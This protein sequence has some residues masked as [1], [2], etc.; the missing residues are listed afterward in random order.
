VGSSRDAIAVSK[1]LDRLRPEPRRPDELDP[2]PAGQRPRTLVA[3]DRP[4]EA[5]LPARAGDAD[6]L[7]AQPGGAHLEPMHHRAQRRG[8]PPA[9]R[10]LQGVDPRPR[11]GEH[12]LQPLDRA[13]QLRAF[14]QLARHLAPARCDLAFA[15]G[16]LA[17]AGGDLALEV[18]LD[19][20]D[21]AGELAPCLPLAAQDASLEELGERHRH[22]LGSGRSDEQVGGQFGERRNR[23][24]RR[25]G[26]RGNVARQVVVLAHRTGR[27]RDRP[28]RAGNR[29]RV[30]QECQQR[31]VPLGR[32][33]VVRE[34]AGVGPPGEAL[35]ECAQRG[36]DD[37][38][39]GG[40][41]HRQRVRPGLRYLRREQERRGRLGG[42]Q[43]RNRLVVVGAGGADRNP[44]SGR[45]RSPGRADH[46]EG[47]RQAPSRGVLCAADR[48]GEA[49][50]RREVAEER[51]PRRRRN[52]REVG[53]GVR[54]DIEPERGEVAGDSRRDVACGGNP[55]RGAGKRRAER[56]APGL[57]VGRPRRRPPGEAGVAAGGVGFAAV[58]AFRRHQHPLRADH[59]VVVQRPVVRNAERPRQ[60][61]RG[62]RVAVQVVEV[63]ADDRQRAEQRAQRRGFDGQ[64]EVELEVAVLAPQ[65]DVPWSRGHEAQ[66]LAA[67][68]EKPSE[69]VDV[70]AHAAAP[71]VRHHQNG[72]ARRD[73]E[74]VERFALRGLREFG[75][76][77][78]RWRESA[79]EVSPEPVI[80][81]VRRAG[82]PARARV[83]VVNRARAPAAGGR[84]PASANR[85]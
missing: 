78:Q 52:E 1:R 69:L 29:G 57:D 13:L 2:Q 56:G 43:R 34:Q 64:R 30:A 75:G 27:Q 44:G 35:G 36:R 23:R 55:P 12:R 54:P 11:G 81:T 19:D 77:L 41:R 71:A 58:T 48:E 4:G 5:R 74:T 66:H 61:E 46:P 26:D 76:G 51:D 24:G 79:G 37:R 10:R 67:I 8:H 17:L 83:P 84:T 42:E 85:P 47:E 49:L 38:Q 70:T 80:L 15:G 62:A 72:R 31:G 40:N 9:R 33:R 45:Q 6:T 14:A 68:G 65:R 50:F 7:R 53:L 25:D 16:D 18:G 32:R 82:E 21:A 73:D 39:P 59:R 63:D 22:R 3:Q 60:P 28:G 20:D